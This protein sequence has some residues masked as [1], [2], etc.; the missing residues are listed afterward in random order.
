MKS[1][2]LFL[3]LGSSL[4]LASAAQADEALAKAKGCLACHT[5]EAKVLGPAYK[6]VAKKYKGTK[7]AEAT[8]AQHI[9]KGTPMPAGMGWQKEGQASLPFMP[10]NASVNPAEATRLAK[11]I[12][13]LQ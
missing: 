7:D 11:W 12:L 13:S 4:L 9:I 5:V 3:L 8:L 1:T 6:A 2:K 10:P